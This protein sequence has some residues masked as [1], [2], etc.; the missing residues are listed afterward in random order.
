MDRDDDILITGKRHDFHA[1][2][3]V[4]FSDKGVIE[5][6]KIKFKA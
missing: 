2:Y 4:G 1:G 6:V 3:E 5:G